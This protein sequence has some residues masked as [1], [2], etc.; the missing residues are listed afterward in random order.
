MDKLIGCLITLLIVFAV[1]AFMAW[2]VMLLWNWVIVA[3]F[4]GAPKI[5]FWVAFGLL[6]IINILFN[7]NKN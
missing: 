1:S 5:T 4:V 7:K 3:I 2:I 6:F